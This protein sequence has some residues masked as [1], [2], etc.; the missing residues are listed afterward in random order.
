MT[1]GDLEPPNV[2]GSPNDTRR[3]VMWVIAIAVLLSVIGLTALSRLVEG[4]G[5]WFNPADRNL[6]SG[7][8]VDVIQGVLPSLGL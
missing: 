5:N 8:R 4:S 2:G 1:N 3:G 7:E 6:T